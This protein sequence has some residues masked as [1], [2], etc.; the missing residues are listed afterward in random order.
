MVF[1][2]SSLLLKLIGTKEEK[3]ISRHD[4]PTTVCG[5]RKPTR[6]VIKNK[7]INPYNLLKK[8]SL[9]CLSPNTFFYVVLP[10]YQILI[11]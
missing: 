6:E 9:K 7:L 4:K 1:S 11:S 2:A 3:Y 5:F 10:Y 8:L